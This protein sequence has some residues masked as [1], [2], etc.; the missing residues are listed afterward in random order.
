MANIV[1]VFT[2]VQYL[3]GTFG[4]AVHNPVLLIVKETSVLPAHIFLF[5]V[6][7]PPK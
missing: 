4:A 3:A 2:A 7:Y 6:L 1:H 5:C